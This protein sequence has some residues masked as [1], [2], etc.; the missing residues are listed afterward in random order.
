MYRASAHSIVLL[1]I[2]A[3]PAARSFSAQTDSAPATNREGLE[4]FETN[5]RPLL[6]KS[7]YECHSA[8]AKIIK[9]GLRL[10]S[11]EGWRK[12]GDSGPALVPGEPGKSL[13]VTVV[14]RADEESPTPRKHKLSPEQIA[15]LEA[16][17]NMG[18]PDPRQET[19]VASSGATK[20]VD[21]EAARKFWS[22]QPVKDP[23][24][25]RVKGRAN[26]PIDQFVLAKLEQRGMTQGATADKRTLIRRVTFDLIGLPPTPEEIDVFL[27][28]PSP[29]A[30]ATVVDRLLAS[31]HYGE[32]WGRHWLDVVRYAD[33]A[34]DSSDY[35]I[36]Q[37]YLYRNYVIDSFNQDKPYDQFLREQIAGDLLPAAN[38]P[39]KRENTI[40]TGFVAI[41]RRFGT[42][43]VIQLTI[44]DTIDTLG[45]AV[46]G[47]SLGCAR[48]HDHKF[49]PIPTQD[50]YALYG[51]FNST[52]YPHPGSENDK[53][54]K[55]FVP[56]I[57]PAEVET[58]MKP[59]QA[60]QDEFDAEAK[61]LEKERN[62]LM[63][64]SVK[65]SAAEATESS[66]DGPAP[67]FQSEKDYYHALL[68]LKN[69]RD[70][71]TDTLPRIESAYA[72]AEGTP[73]NSRVQ[74]RGELA[75]LGEE[76]PRHF[77][78]VLGGQILPFGDKGS[79]RHELAGWLADSNNPLTARV[80]VNRLWQH[81][82]GRGIVESPNDFG[83]RGSAPTHPELLDYLA[84]RFVA[85]GWS[86]KAMHRL[87]LLSRTYQL[88]GADNPRYVKMDPG[89]LWLWKFNRQRLHAEI[90]RDALL[91]VS[92][93]LDLSV[94]GAHPFPP[95]NKW[96]FTQHNEFHA[97]YEINRRSVYLM[98]QR[99]R[100]HPYLGIFDGADPNSTTGARSL[101]TTP[102]QALFM[103][104]D[105][106]M[107][108]QAAGFAARLED[109]KPRDA[110]RIALAYL[111]AYG[112]PATRT[113]VRQGEAY[114]R[115]FREKAV[116]VNR[117]LEERERMAWTS[118]A[119]V[120]LSSN[121][122][123][124]VE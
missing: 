103:M 72:V 74:R 34:G 82:F 38:E 69:K 66:A 120:L 49:D 25:P 50:Y 77:L 71:F 43:S 24:P 80:I 42:G 7:C 99:S 119:R 56:L 28:D 108:E 4:F 68:E 101:S 40:A 110:E 54:Q 84:S 87:L 37:A 44:E 118:F 2:L 33:T 105:R 60:K 65:K 31:A 36:P 90:I 19:A 17:V 123:V 14:R 8:D 122:F 59:F 15:D 70:A 79:G 61:Q 47:L 64:R 67:R 94:G 3:G 96:D 75:S 26:N 30:F 93:W 16:W 85:A 88:A 102:L 18:A 12:G 58:I 53:R 89:N 86:I 113:E 73:A 112:R 20:V 81:H 21:F 1:A 48:C 62:Q 6:V 63:K 111:L 117:F 109:A 78:Q 116:P 91:S 23:T 51:I 27:T 45:K 29:D 41:S 92:G 5:I 98:Q 104:N 76:V 46:L 39:R 95:E 114:L 9:G 107:Q 13:L 57:P 83:A 22:F 115:A 100:R 35:P 97:L 55:D 121:E 10:D 32:R 106:F 52:R 11:P 124:F